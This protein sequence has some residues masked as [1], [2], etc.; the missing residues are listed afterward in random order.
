[1]YFALFLKCYF[2]SFLLHSTETHARPSPVIFKSYMIIFKI[3]YI[4]GLFVRS[5][6]YKE[7]ST[8]VINIF[9]LVLG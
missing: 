4:S 8:F 6:A 9:P 2:C 1:M 3:A 7:I 5:N